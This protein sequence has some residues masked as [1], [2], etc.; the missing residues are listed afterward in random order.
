MS[1]QVSDG[2]NRFASPKLNPEV[3]SRTRRCIMRR[4][5]LLAVLLVPLSFALGA[6][7]PSKG[8][9]KKVGNVYVGAIGQ[10]DGWKFLPEGF[11]RVVRDQGK[12]LYREFHSKV[13]TGPNATKKQLLEGVAWMC[14]NA[15]EGDLVMLFIACHGSC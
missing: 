14:E 6:D 4:L 10:E 7:E 11:E 8:D 3:S 2:Q 13:L 12:E 5:W 15:K 1:H 9:A